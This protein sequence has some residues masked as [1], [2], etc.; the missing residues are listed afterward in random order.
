[1]SQANLFRHQAY[2]ATPPTSPHH[3]VS[4]GVYPPVES[5]AFRHRMQQVGR[6]FAQADVGAVYLVHGTFVGPDA[7]GVLA[8][9]A[10]V[11]PSAGNA[12]RGVIKRIV[13]K[14]AG[15]VGGVAL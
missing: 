10:R 9:L 13:D 2:K 1:M 15:E 6:A 12:V 5:D 8:E 4:P 3:L 7:L 11:F 14:V